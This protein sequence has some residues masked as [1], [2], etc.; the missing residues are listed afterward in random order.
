MTLIRIVTLSVLKAIVIIAQENEVSSCQI[1]DKHGKDYFCSYYCHYNVIGV[2]VQKYDNPISVSTENIQK[3]QNKNYI[4]ITLKRL[5]KLQKFNIN[6]EVK[7]PPYT[8]STSSR[9]SI[10]STVLQL[11][12]SRYYLRSKSL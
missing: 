7:P 3:T 2:Q 8:S 9:P 11:L 12:F 1:L 4:I 10:S 6:K 5:E